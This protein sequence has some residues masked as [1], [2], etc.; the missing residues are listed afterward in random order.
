MGRGPEPADF[1]KL[2][3]KMDQPYGVV[4]ASA[5]GKQPIASSNRLLVTAMARVEPTGYR[6]VDTW[7]RDVADPGR[8]PL[9]Q[10]PVRA[11]IRWRNKGNVKAYA[12]DNSGARVHPVTLETVED[13]VVLNI[14]G[15][16]PT[17]H[18]E[19]VVE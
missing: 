11:R 3:V 10:E 15:N 16:E 13:G 5:A 19:L 12:L 7:K 9:L 17:F 8:P 1:E 6:W 18:W 2:Q 4:V 14:L